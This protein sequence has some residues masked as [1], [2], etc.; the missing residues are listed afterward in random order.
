MIEA[1]GGSW[2]RFIWNGSIGVAGRA[3]QEW[4]QPTAPALNS[5]TT[6]SAWPE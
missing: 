6:R 3:T 1:S 2:W 4:P 5:A